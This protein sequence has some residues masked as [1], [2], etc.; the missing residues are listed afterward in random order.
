LS[1]NLHVVD[2]QSQEFF[3]SLSGRI[4]FICYAEESGC[5]FGTSASN[6]VHLNNMACKRGLNGVKVKACALSDIWVP[7]HKIWTSQR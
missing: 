3:R 6:L 4:L 7:H 1:E 5:F 2:G